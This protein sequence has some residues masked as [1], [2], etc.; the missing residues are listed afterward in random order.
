MIAT[1]LIRDK[2]T[3]YPG[4]AEMYALGVRGQMGRSAGFGFISFGK[5]WFGN[6]AF[7]LGVYRKA[8]KGYNQY[9]G[10]PTP[11]NKTY[12][13]LCRSYNP[14]NPQTEDQQANRQK[15]ADAVS[16]WQDLT[17]EQKANYNQKGSRFNRRGYNV[18]IQE[19]LKS[20]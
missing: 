1:P 8:V 12:Y 19:Y 2:T 5:N 20:H 16:A 4:V 10:P 14:T 17:T 6:Q 18:F 11:G 13:V 9:T 7:N 3:K 15:I